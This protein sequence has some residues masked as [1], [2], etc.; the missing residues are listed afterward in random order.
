MFLGAP[1]QIS[2]HLTE[3]IFPGSI[4]ILIFQLGKITETTDLPKEYYAA[5]RKE[6]IL[7]FATTW[8]DLEMILLREISQRKR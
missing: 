4:I 7:P 1:S 6:E 8:L 3:A 5:V 2:S